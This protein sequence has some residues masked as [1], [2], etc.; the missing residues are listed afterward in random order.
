MQPV[1]AA[2][3]QMVFLLLALIVT[4]PRLALALTGSQVYERVKDSVVVVGAFDRAGKAVGLGSGVV[5]PSGDIV[6]NY[7]VIKGGVRYVVAQKGKT[8]PAF[9]Q[10]KDPDKDLGL[11]L[12]PGLTATPAQV[13]QASRLKVGEKVFAVGS[14]QGLELSLSEGIVSQLRGGPPPIIQTTV[15]IS[16]GSS[17]GGL[18]N[19]QGELVGIMTFQ[20]K[21]GQNLNFALPV[22]WVREVARKKPKVLGQPAPESSYQSSQRYNVQEMKEAAVRYADHY[23]IP[24]DMFLAYIGVASN[25]NPFAKDSKTSA[26]GLGKISD[27]TGRKL[28]LKITGG[29]DDKRWDPAKNMDAI[30]RLFVQRYEEYGNWKQAFLSIGEPT[31]EYYKRVK[32]RAKQEESMLLV[33]ERNPIVPDGPSERPVEDWEKRA[34]TLTKER[35]WKN[36]LAH[37]L[38]WTKA[39]PGNPDSWGY[40]AVACEELG[41]YKEAVTAH[42]EALR[43]KPGDAYAW[44][45]LGLVYGKLGRYREE[46][47]SYREALRLKPNLSPT[48]YLLGVAYGK[49]SRSREQIEAYREALRLKPDYANAW[50]NLACAYALSG[51]R[52]AALQAVKELRRYDPKKAEELFNLIMKP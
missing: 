22:E 4:W 34:L 17:G 35:D 42:R 37:C 5:L 48:W 30:S 15:A 18:F 20:L 43:L 44:C 12:A 6:T 28:G 16:Q 27:S 41:R 49:L 47:E 26:C 1:F 24:R 21:E 19:D 2:H 29:P 46:I 13:G 50:N 51:N 31:E 10:G 25:W 36:L 38:Q 11:L 3:R 14:P 33:R 23:G 7:H 52:A 9:L 32:N 45:N 8:A 40:L 39:E